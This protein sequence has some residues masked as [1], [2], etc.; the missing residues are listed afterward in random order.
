MLTILPYMLGWMTF[1]LLEMYSSNSW[2]V[3]RLIS[4]LLMSMEGSRKSKITLHW[5][6]FW[7][8]KSG[9]LFV[10]TSNVSTNLNRN[11]V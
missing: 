1:L 4:L 5:S 7:M 6:S 8:N 2:R 9:R 10:G 3:E 11:T